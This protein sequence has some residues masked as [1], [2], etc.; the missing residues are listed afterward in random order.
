MKHIRTIIF[1]NFI[2]PISIAIFILAGG[3]LLVGEHRDAWFISFV[4]LVNSFIG[5]IQEIR[6]YL[7]LR[8]IELMSA[9]RARIIRDGQTEEVLFTELKTGDSILLKTGDEIPADAKITKS[10]SFEVNESILTGESDS[11]PKKVGDKILSSA[12]V[13]AGDAEAEVIAVGDE[14]EA[15]Q[16]TAKLKNYK[17]KLTPIQ[18]K[19][20]K[21]IS[22][23]SWFALAL[24]AIICVV[25]FFI[26]KEDPTTVLKTITSATVP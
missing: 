18:Q 9:P 4:I 24:T 25:Y 3:L 6:A 7:T 13:V 15:G 16:M 20:S 26:F 2:S 22:R 21:L 8:K 1:R 23:L 17:P 5:S 14:T 11:I 10:N 12:I 19:I